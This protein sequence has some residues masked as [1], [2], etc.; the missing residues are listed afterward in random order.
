M[1]LWTLGEYTP[2]QPPSKCSRIWKESQLLMFRPWPPTCGFS[3]WPH[4]LRYRQ[5]G[6]KDFLQSNAIT[7]TTM[8][9]DTTFISHSLLLLTGSILSVYP[10][11]FCVHSVPCSL[12]SPSDIVWE[13]Q[14]IWM[15]V[16]LQ[17]CFVHQNKKSVTK[18]KKKK[19]VLENRKERNNCLQPTFPLGENTHL[20]R[21]R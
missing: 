18:L 17:V 8:S 5:L 13:S 7:V 9:T 14:G 4:V 16:A 12:K 1:S 3:T 2:L 11:C 10:I 21:S 20:L 6:S 19:K 15:Q